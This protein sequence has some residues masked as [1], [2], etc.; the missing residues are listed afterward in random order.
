MIF[1]VDFDGTLSFGKWPECGPVN[2][3]LIEFLKKRKSDGDKVILWTCREGDALSAAVNWCLDY[4]L[5]FDAVNDNLPE[6]VER[7]G[8][9]SRKVS[10]DFY[11]DDRA[12]A[13]NIYKIL[14]GKK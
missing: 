5:K 3:G 8:V 13:G 11:I 1:A 9:N 6:I 12:L 14:E 10:C 7:Y 2:Y 4:G